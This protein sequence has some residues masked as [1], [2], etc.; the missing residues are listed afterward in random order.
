MKLAES[1]DSGRLEQGRLQSC[2][3]PEELSRLVVPCHSHAGQR[4]SNARAHHAFVVKSRVD[5]S[6][7]L[8][9]QEAKERNQEQNS[10]RALSVPAAFVPARSYSGRDLQTQTSTVHAH[11]QDQRMLAWYRSPRRTFPFTTTYLQLEPSTPRRTFL[12]IKPRALSS[13]SR[14]VN[15]GN[16]EK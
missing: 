16:R 10:I 12:L 3:P 13:S 1:P 7:R 5:V 9:C 11:S 8:K 2:R 4:Y 15:G 6:S 14:E